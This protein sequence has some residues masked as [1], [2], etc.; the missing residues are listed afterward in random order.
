MMRGNRRSSTF[1]NPRSSSH[2]RHCP[3]RAARANDSTAEV[4]AGGLVLLKAESIAML[5]EDL[6]VSATEVRVR[7]RF[8]NTSPADIATTVAFPMPELVAETDRMFALPSEDAENLAGVRDK[9]RRQA[10][11]RAGGAQGAGARRRPHGAA[12]QPQ[13]SAGARIA[14]RWAKRSMRCRASSGTN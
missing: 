14:T 2:S 3:P 13:H 9:G 10:G 4:A 12:A 1:A 8:F 11:H 7:Y 5:A 6:F